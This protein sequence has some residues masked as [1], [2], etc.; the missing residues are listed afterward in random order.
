MSQQ[1][2][3]GFFPPA[4]G[5]DDTKLQYTFNS[6]VMVAAII[7]LFFVVFFILLLHVYAKWFWHRSS[8]SVYIR[9]G[10]ASART[11]VSTSVHTG[12]DAAIIAQLP[13]F[14][15]KAAMAASANNLEAGYDE[16]M[17]PLLECAVCLSEF[18]ENEKGR[19][20]PSCRHT[21]HTEC[22]DMWLF[23]HSTCP[24][25]RSVV[26]PASAANSNEQPQGEEQEAMG[27]SLNT[28]GN[29]TIASN[30][31]QLPCNVLFWGNEARVTSTQEPSSSAMSISSSPSSAPPRTRALPQIMI[32]IPPIEAGI[33]LTISTPG[34]R[35]SSKSTQCHTD[36]AACSS[37]QQTLKSPAGLRASLKRMLSR[38]SSRHMEGNEGSPK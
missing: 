20:L 38:Q 30:A 25:C 26:L 15:Y 5:P 6:K 37:Q 10:I 11:A 32:D 29:H 21:F 16:S 27:P 33:I 35:S 17:V 2:G 18:Q 28:E 3:N 24:L 23:S 13:T 36:Q 31:V 7:I 12:L 19:M 9:R 1:S 14:T 22:I 4:T 8:T 34:R